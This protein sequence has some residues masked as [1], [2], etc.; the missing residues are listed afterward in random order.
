MLNAVFP[1]PRT[2]IWFGTAI[3]L[4]LPSYTCSLM[5]HRFVAIIIFITIVVNGVA[6]TSSR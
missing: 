6:W 4:T 5:A 3:S 1:P 2:V